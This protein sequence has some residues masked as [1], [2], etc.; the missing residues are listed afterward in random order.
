MTT[1]KQLLTLAGCLSL[2]VAAFQFILTF[3]PTLCRYF[4]APEELLTGDPLWLYLASFS[5]TALFGIWGLYGLS[6]AGRIRRLPLLRTGLLAIGGIYTLRGLL[7]IPA[8]LA[9]VGLVPADASL[10]PQAL[11][12]SLVALSTGV[13]YLVGTFGSLQDL[14]P[15][16]KSV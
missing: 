10:L 6:G 4:G 13:L 14:R 3:S 2:A 5:A 12:A 8:T 7:L 15:R 16:P 1:S 9:A 11:L